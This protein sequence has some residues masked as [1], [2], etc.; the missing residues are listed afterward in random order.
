MLHR[1][2]KVITVGVIT[3]ALIGTTLFAN[4]SSDLDENQNELSSANAVSNV[5]AETLNDWKREFEDKFGVK[6]GVAQNGKTFFF[7]EAVVRVNPLDPAYAKEL[8]LTYDKAMLN[9]QS[10]FILQTY[11]TLSA[12]TISDNFEDDSTNAREFDPVKLK[13][14]AAKGKVSLILDKFVDVIDKKLDSM[15]VEQGGPVDEIQK[16]TVEQKKQLFKDNF[17]KE[18]TKKAF[19]S[20][21]G[22][23]PVQTKIITTSRGGK[24]TV[25]LGVIAIMSEKT[26]QFAKDIAKRRE[27]NVK[28]RASSIEKIL[29]TDDQ[30]FLDEIGL[31]YVY[32]EK[33]R[34]ML[35]SYGRWS[36]VGKTSNA[37]RYERKIQN[38]KEKAR[39][40]AEA[41]IGEFMKSNINAAQG[42]ISESINE[43]I[44]KKIS[45]IDNNKIVGTD[46]QSQEIGETLDQSFKK[47][48]KSSKFKLRGTSEITT[49]E[50]TDEN[51]ILHVGS[52]V[53]W[54]YAQLEN[55]N[56]IVHGSKKRKYKKQ[57]RKQAVKNVSR[58]SR[59]VNSMDD[60]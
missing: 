59:V 53:S 11:G 49:W 30:G 47:L 31:R 4:A 25:K 60:F 17:R 50:A 19:A 41:N 39:M 43:E 5:R 58:S 33:G 1:F 20:M 6:I 48:Q 16:Q 32:D 22:L 24:K 8:A 28:G 9:L 37:A 51:G 15:L 52:V 14:E 42:S 7:G 38:A 57:E 46:E 12:K 45:T 3:S 56:N 35:I 10:N 29:P 40:F 18:I 26:V 13:K 34:P 44:A 27:T 2:K 21:S 36:V 23:V 55:A 54:R